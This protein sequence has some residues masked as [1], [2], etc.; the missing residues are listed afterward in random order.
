MFGDASTGVFGAILYLVTPPCREC[1]TGQVQFI[2]AKGKLA[3]PT[4]EQDPKEDTVPRWELQSLVTAGHLVEFVVSDIDELKGKPIFIWGDNRPALSWCSSDDID[5]IY[6]FRSVSPSK[7][8]SQ[9][10]SEVC[11]V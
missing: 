9:G 3:P 7:V 4:K 2:K 1:P 6:V 11:K 8:M 10:N 5:D